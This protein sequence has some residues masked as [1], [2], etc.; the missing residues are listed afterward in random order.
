MANPTQIKSNSIALSAGGNSLA[1]VATDVALKIDPAEEA[2]TPIN[3][4]FK[5]ALPGI[6]SWSLDATEF[7][8]TSDA[9]YGALM[10]AATTRALIDVSYNDTINTYTGSAMVKIDTSVKAGGYLTAKISLL[11]ASALTITAGGTG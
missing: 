5:I 10:T 7:V 11:G 3:S 1:A 2:V 8:I 9:A 6:I 4:D